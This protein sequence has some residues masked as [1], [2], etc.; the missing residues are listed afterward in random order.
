LGIDY[1]KTGHGR[2]AVCFF[3][4]VI[5]YDDDLSTSAIVI[6]NAHNP[7]SRRQGG[8]TLGLASFEEFHNAR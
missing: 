1:C 7:R 5:A 8:F 3:F 4:S 2:D 6:T